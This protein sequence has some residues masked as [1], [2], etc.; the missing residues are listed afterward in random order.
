MASVEACRR[1]PSF[2]AGIDLDGPLKERPFKTDSIHQ[3]F[4]TIAAGTGLSPYNKEKPEETGYE[5]WDAFHKIASS[6]SI[7][8]FL[9]ADHSDFTMK[10]WFFHTMGA[11]EM[12][13]I[14]LD[15][16]RA[17]HEKTCASIVE[18]FTLNLKKNP[19]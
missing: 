3:P 15:E 9:D 16:L 6:S 13:G 10:P 14:A 19:K 7:Q 11:P 8:H 17:F 18:F 4:L 12:A 1:N 5:D 2:K